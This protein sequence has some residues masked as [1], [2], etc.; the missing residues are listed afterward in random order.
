MK[1]GNLF[2][3]K[4]CFWLLFPSKEIAVAAEAIGVKV[5]TAAAA[6]AAYISKHLKCNVSYIEPKSIFC[7]LE[8]DGEFLK[9]LSTNGEL[10]WVVYPENEDLVKGCIKE[11][12]V[13]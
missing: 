4:K 1:I 8:K 2:Q 13:E 5:V 3:F 7:L 10:G 11:V 12:K 9:I 6:E